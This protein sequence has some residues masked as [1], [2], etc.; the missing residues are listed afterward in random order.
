[1][2]WPL[3]LPEYDENGINLT[4]IRGNLRLTP[5]ERI[6]KGELAREQ[7]ILDAVRRGI[8][9]LKAGRTYDL[10]EVFDELDRD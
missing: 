1:M 9:D 10:D 6:C 7:A 4:E 2:S 3:E 8:A 5:L